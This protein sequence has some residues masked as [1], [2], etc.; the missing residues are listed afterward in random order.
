MVA[1]S[2]VT[3]AV[4]NGMGMSH[5]T[6]LGTATQNT[7]TKGGSVILMTKEV[8]LFSFDVFPVLFGVSFLTA[9]DPRYNPQHEPPPSKA[10]TFVSTFRERHSP[11]PAIPYPCSG[12]TPLSQ[13]P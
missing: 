2:D 8:F 12:I 6:A 4:P 11:N 13:A 1:L 5:G 3:D 7:I 10:L 9:T